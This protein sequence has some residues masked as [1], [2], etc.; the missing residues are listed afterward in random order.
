M[1]STWKGPVLMVYRLCSGNE[2]DK[3]NYDPTR[4]FFVRVLRYDTIRY[5]YTA[6][7]FPPAG[8]GPYTFSRRAQTATC[9]RRNSADHRT[10][11]VN[12]TY[13]TIKQK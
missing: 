11:T 6:I 13:K 5:L 9:I 8:S 2:I 10:K 7:G 3:E 12:K 4:L 1:G